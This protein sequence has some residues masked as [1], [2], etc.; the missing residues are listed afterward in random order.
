MASEAGNCAI[1]LEEKGMISCPFCSLGFCKNCLQSSFIYFTSVA[2]P[3]CR[4]ELSME[5]LQRFYTKAYL[6]K[7]FRQ[8]KE[9]QLFSEESALLQNTL[10]VLAQERERDERKQVVRSEIK[11]IANKMLELERKRNELRR[12]LRGILRGTFEEKERRAFVQPCP[13][14][15]CRGFLSTRWKCEVCF[16]YFCSDCREEIK[17]NEQEEIKEEHKCDPQLVESIKFAEKGTKRCPN[18]GVAIF[19]IE[20]CRQMFCVSCHQA[21]DWETLRI[22]HEPVHNPHY[23]QWL[24]QRGHNERRIGDVPC[25]GLVDAFQIRSPEMI[26]IRAGIG[27]INEF[28][29]HNARNIEHEQNNENIRKDYLMK[30]IDLK[31]FK[32]RVYIAGRKHDRMQRYFRILQMFVNIASDL[33]RD[34]VLNH[35]EAK[36][37]QELSEFREIVNNDIRKIKEDKYTS[38]KLIDQNFNFMRDNEREAVRR[39][40][41][42]KVSYCT[43]PDCHRTF[44][45]REGER[46]FKVCG[47][48][49]F[50]IQNENKQLGRLCICKMKT[51]IR[52]NQPCGRVASNIEGTICSMHLPK[53]KRQYF[54]E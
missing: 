11:E 20:G 46:A 36:G 26:R 1:C 27:G 43:Y 37:V 35:T 28:L 39:E 14:E 38:V 16:R 52:K 41:R 44:Y 50:V 21:F 30:K 6:E 54:D 13:I 10:G 9:D 5:F 32:R 51:G 8:K 33:I 15:G 42:S 4:K 2:C 45:E 31:E 18:C 53:L 48:H 19:K 24:N 29:V 47:N 40:A 23:F 12:E 34:H 3:D 49:R 22:I 7:L 25:G 17:F